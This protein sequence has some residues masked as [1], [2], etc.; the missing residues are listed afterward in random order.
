MPYNEFTHLHAAD[1]RHLAP[2][3]NGLTETIPV[4]QGIATSQDAGYQGWLSTE[5]IPVTQGIA[6]SQDAGCQGWLSG[7]VGEVR[8]AWVLHAVCSGI[9]YAMRDDEC[10]DT[11]YGFAGY[12][13]HSMRGS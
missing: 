5:T 7:S 4:T 11:L 12:G 6:T 8:N 10:V 13:W 1:S 3:C 2:G 9:T